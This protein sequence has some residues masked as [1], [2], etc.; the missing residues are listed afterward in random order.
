MLLLGKAI[1]TFG[2]TSVLCPATFSPP[3]SLQL[4]QLPSVIR[5]QD[6]FLLPRGESVSAIT[7]FHVAGDQCCAGAFS[8]WERICLEHW[9][10]AAPCLFSGVCMV[11]S[12]EWYRKEKMRAIE[13]LLYV[14]TEIVSPSLL[15]GRRTLATIT[16]ITCACWIE[17]NRFEA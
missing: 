2:V 15:L 16:Y 13:T 5:H 1:N 6:C 3:W 9:H 4:H 8:S 12:L 17:K 7:I 11:S 10:Q 14:Q